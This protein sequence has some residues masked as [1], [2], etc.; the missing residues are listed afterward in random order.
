MRIC[1]GS[2]A[3]KWNPGNAAN[4]FVRVVLSEAGALLGG[5]TDE[6]WEE[7]L[8]FFEHRCAYTGE[9]LTKDNTDQDH[10]IP[11]NREHCGLHLFGNV[12]PSTKAANNA[13]LSQHYEAFVQDEARKARIQRF[14]DT[15]A[16]PKRWPCSA[17]S[18]ATA[19]RSTTPS[20]PS[21]A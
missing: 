6:Q 8:R 19:R 3:R 9:P 5:L 4:I 20:T 15:P 18:V 2:T 11:M 7:T 14:L 13:K 17:T 12:V 10:A 21:A 16:T 1:R